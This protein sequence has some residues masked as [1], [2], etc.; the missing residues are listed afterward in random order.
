MKYVDI[1]SELI[2]DV[3]NSD[4]EAYRG[5]LRQSLCARKL[6]CTVFDQKYSGKYALRYQGGIQHEAYHRTSLS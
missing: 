6:Y 1:E 3:Q 4:P 2:A 5:R